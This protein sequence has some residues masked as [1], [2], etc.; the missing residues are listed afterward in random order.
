MK[1]HRI[2]RFLMMV[3]ALAAIA[4]LAY[5]APPPG[6]GPNGPKGGPPDN[7]GPKQAVVNG[8]AT[9]V[10]GSQRRFVVHRANGQDV[11]I[12]TNAQTTFLGQARRQLSLNSN[13]AF[14][15][16][17]SDKSVQVKGTP[18]ANGSVT[19]AQVFVKGPAH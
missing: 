15:S 7:R 17:L 6:K 4:S 18:N 13:N 2:V 9:N 5:G 19:A 16:A 3:I 1:E 11:T 8:V 12:V 14:V 10:N